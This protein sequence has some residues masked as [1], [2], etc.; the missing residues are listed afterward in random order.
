[1]TRSTALILAFMLTF[2]IIGGSFSICAELMANHDEFRSMPD[3]S[4]ACCCE[5][6]CQVGQQDQSARTQK[7]SALLVLSLIQDRSPLEAIPEP[8]TLPI[9]GKISLDQDSHSATSVKVYLLKT[10]FLI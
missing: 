6:K 9:T 4:A 10:S 5:D 2:G 8:G 3:C 1:M 7:S